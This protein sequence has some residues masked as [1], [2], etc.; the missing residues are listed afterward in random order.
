[1]PN[2]AI[3][4]TEQMLGELTF[5]DVIG[6]DE[7]LKFATISCQ[8]ANVSTTEIQGTLLNGRNYSHLLYTHKE[9][10]VTISANELTPEK[11]EFLLLFWLSPFKYISINNGGTWQKYIQVRTEG[12]AFPIEYIDDCKYLPEINFNFITANPVRS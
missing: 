8:P 3:R 5:D 2:I 10:K 11:I 9:Y 1:M 7:Q 4:R 12:G 6:S